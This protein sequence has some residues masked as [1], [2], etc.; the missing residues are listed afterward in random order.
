MVQGI[1]GAAVPVAVLAAVA[2]ARDE[3]WFRES[4]QPSVDGGCG[5]SGGCKG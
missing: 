1:Q 4:K 3:R 2:V 5:A